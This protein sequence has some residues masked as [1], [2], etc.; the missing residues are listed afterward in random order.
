MFNAC[1]GLWFRRFVH[2]ILASEIRS[3]TQGILPFL[4]FFS[5]KN[6]RAFRKFFSKYVA[7]ISSTFSSEK[8]AIAALLHNSNRIA[9]K[10][11]TYS[12]FNVIST[13]QCDIIFKTNKLHVKI[14]THI[15]PFLHVS[16]ADCHFRDPHQYLKPSEL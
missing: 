12:Y 2:A 6:F 5:P 4:C 11:K 9:D 8:Q 14:H 3:L 7:D 1:A 16:A 10:R 15:S 13:V